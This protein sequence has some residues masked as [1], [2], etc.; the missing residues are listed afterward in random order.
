M[1]DFNRTTFYGYNYPDHV[2]QNDPA[3]AYS[4]WSKFIRDIPSRYV[5][6]FPLPPHTLSIEI[7]SI[8]RML[9]MARKPKFTE[10]E[11]VDLTLTKADAKKFTDWVS[12]QDKP[13]I[14]WLSNLITDGY[15]VSQSAD[16][17]HNCV[18]VAV[19]GKST[20][21]FNT[22]RCFT[23]RAEEIEEALWMAVYKHYVVCDGASWGEPHNDT[24]SWG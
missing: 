6:K 1:D 5:H 3:S 15:K 16:F 4:E 22:D 23:S 14:L 19:T 10:I 20:A 24:L 12:K 7:P 11:F 18:I 9:S 8:E 13:L 21:A 2:F 17:E